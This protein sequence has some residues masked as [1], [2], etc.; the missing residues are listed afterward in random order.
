MRQARQLAER[1]G[2]LIARC[3]DCQAV[4]KIDVGFVGAERTRRQRDDLLAHRFAGELRRAAGIHRL[5]A[6]ERADALGDGTGIADRHHD[7]LDAAADLFGDDLRQRGAGALAL[8]GGAGRDRDLA[9]RQ[10]ANGDALERTEP[11]AFDIIADADAD[12]PALIE[13][14]ALPLPETV[15]AGK[16]QRFVLS[17][18]IVAA[19]IDQR[20]AV[21]EQ[22]ADRV[23]HL[24]RLDEIAPPH[25]GAIERQFARDAVEQPLHREHRLRPAG[26]AH[27]R[28][29]HF[30]GEDDD[31]LQMIGRHHIGTGHGHGG[32]I[33]HDD[34]PRHES[35]AIVQ[36]AAA[37]AQNLAVSVDGDRHVPILIALLGRAEEMFAAILDPFHRPAKLERRRRDHRFLRIKDRL[38]PETAADVRRDHAD[39]FQIAIEQIG[40]R[41][42]AEMRRL[43]AGPYRQHVRHRIVSCQHGTRFQR[44]AAAA[45]LPEHFFEDMRGVTRTL[46]RRRRKRAG[47]GR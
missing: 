39:R 24:F 3:R 37:H 35:A 5:A 4:L 11:G 33:G 21:A 17:F 13:C 30:V 12:Q 34:A 44:H 45:M 25:F 2:W 26:A 23:G 15:I 27:R 18:R 16:P 9:A 47:S 7:V 1:N 19:V 29:R 43:R 22:Q 38:R 28:G 20:L 14:R 36:H 31:G 6:G 32:D 40:K 8:I 10:D 41:A 46:H 42:A